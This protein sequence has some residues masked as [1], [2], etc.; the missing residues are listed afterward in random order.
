MAWTTCAQC[1]ER[2]G[3]TDETEAVLRKSGQGFHCPWGHPLSFRLGPSEEELLRKER[4]TLKQQNAMW[5]ATA[6]EQRDR[7]SAAERRAS[8]ARGQVTKLK[9]RAAAGVCPCCN[10][11]FTNLARHM[12]GQHPAFAAEIPEAATAQ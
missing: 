3:L 6:D 7:A 1:K 4:D 12:A 10:R 5:R 2:F 11:T 8:A 9:N